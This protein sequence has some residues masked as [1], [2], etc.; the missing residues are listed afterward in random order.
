MPED[1]NSTDG[2]PER[3]SLIVYSGTFERVHYAL[4]LASAAAAVGIPATL[5][6]TME[7]CRALVEPGDDGT[8]AWR[9][10]P[11]GEGEDGER[12][13]TA[14]A[15]DDRYTA[16]GVAGFDELLVACA[17]LGVRFMVCEMGLRAKG[18]SRAALRDDLPIEEGG[19]VTFLNDASRAGAML[20]I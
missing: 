2:R 18:L 6:F 1:P 20:F 13:H 8:P 11:A 15:V 10:L 3:L 12:G 4:V 5:F 16:H 17:E 7:A 19:V 14:G 9:R